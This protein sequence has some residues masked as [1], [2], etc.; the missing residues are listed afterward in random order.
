LW[1]GASWAF[2]L[3]GVYHA[4]LI[5]IERKVSKYFTFISGQFKQMLGWVIV[6][7]LAMLSWIPFR[8]NSLSNV[9]IMFRKV[10]LF[11]GGFSRS[12]SE[13]VYLITV[14]LT[15]LVIISF[16]IHD[17]I[18]K[19]IKNKF[20]LYALVVFLSIIL[21]TTLDLTFLRPISQFIYFQF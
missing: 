1:H 3:W 19:Y 13:N 21:M 9:F 15:L 16:L 7:P 20:I 11:E 4:I 2:V 12:F 5:L 10:F 14:V 17:F 8:D 6:F 18:L